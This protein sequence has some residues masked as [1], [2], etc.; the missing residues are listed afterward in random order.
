MVFHQ[1]NKKVTLPVLTMNGT[2]IECTDNVNFLG[3]DL[4][5]HMNLKSH[6]NIIT[7]KISKT[8]SIL[9]RLKHILPQH[10]RIHIYNALIL[11]YI[12][13]G[14]LLLGYNGKRIFALQKRQ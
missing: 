13:Y 11:S 6:V 10:T 4:N 12:N 1:P 14:L 5:K 3:I 2:Q 8:I 7:K 9:K